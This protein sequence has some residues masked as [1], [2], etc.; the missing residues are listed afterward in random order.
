MPVIVD[1]LHL[2]AFGTVI[3]PISYIM[4]WNCETKLKLF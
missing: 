3:G 2:K 1:D 4:L